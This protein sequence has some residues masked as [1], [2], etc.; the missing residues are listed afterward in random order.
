[1]ARSARPGGDRSGGVSDVSG[2]DRLVA[3][4]RRAV[5]GGD[6]RLYGDARGARSRSSTRCDARVGQH[7]W[8]DCRSDR[9][10]AV[11]LSVT[12][13]SA[14]PVYFRV[15][16]LNRFRDLALW[17]RL[18]SWVGDVVPDHAD[19]LQPAAH[20]VHD[21]GRSR[22]RCHDRDHGIFCGLHS[23]PVAVRHRLGP[24]RRA[25]GA[26]ATGILAPPLRC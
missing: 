17:L 20:G 6:N 3:A 13:V 19:V 8:S 7:R 15:R 11:R 4:L 16:R 9:A 5:V 18:V 22:R 23:Q 21:G 2:P 26:T 1:M 12:A 14:L 24:C 25:A 10:A